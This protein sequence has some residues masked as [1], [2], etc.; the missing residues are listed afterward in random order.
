VRKTPPL[1]G[2][3]GGANAIII[4][5]NAFN[6]LMAWMAIGLDLTVSRT[7]AMFSGVPLEKL[8]YDG[9][10]IVLGIVP[11]VFS[12]ALF[13]APLARAVVRP[14]R[15]RRLARENGR[16][17]V[18][19]EILS[20][21]KAHRAVPADALAAAWQKASGKAPDEK[22]LTR[23]V[24]RLGGDVDLE[25]AER[26]EPGVRYRFADLEAEEEALAAERAAASEEEAKVGKVVF[27]SDN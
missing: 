13:A 5:L 7:F 11:L 21:V 8:P 25:A 3:D 17:S 12:L 2:N 26:G 16:A 10:P 20:A 15:A 6:A 23:E 1:T 22:E 14:L 9:V 18:L 24:V 4:A 27:A 19:R